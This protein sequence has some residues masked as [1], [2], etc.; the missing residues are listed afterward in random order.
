MLG[1]HSPQGE[2]FRPDHLLREHVGRDSFYVALS[3]ARVRLFRDE[4][5]AGLYGERGRPSVP[6]SQLC[7]ALLLQTR[8][9]VSDEEAIKRSAYDLRWKVALGLDLE[10]KLCAKSTLQLFRAKLILHESY[11]KIFQASVEECRKQGLL[12]RHKLEVAIDTTP[13]LGRGAVKDTFNLV[14][15]QIRRLVREVAK[16]KGYELGELVAQHGLGRHFAS[17]FKSQ[18]DL[19]WDDAEQKRAVVAQLVGDARV[20]LE[21]AK[22]ALRGY[23]SDAKQTRAVREARELLADLV[24][25][26]IEEEPDDGGGPQIRQGTARDRIVSATDPE[27]RHGR[28]SRSKRFDGYKASVAVDTKAGVVVSTDV[29]PGN[30]HDAEG[31]GDL[32]K[33]GS[34]AA[35]REVERVLADT[36]YGTT[37]AREEIAE[38]TNGAEVV[39]KVPPAPRRKGAEFTADDFDV[40]LDAGVATCPAGK[41]SVRH[42]PAKGTTPHRF[43]FSRNDCTACPMRSRC[44]T[45]KADARSL[46]ISEGHEDLRRLRRRQRTKRFKETYR[47]RS[48]VEH[49]IARLVQLGIRQARYLGRSKVAFQVCIAAAVANLVLACASGSSLATRPSEG[50]QPPVGALRFFW[51]SIQAAVVAIAASMLAVASIA[52]L[53]RPALEKAPSRPGF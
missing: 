16:L 44:T 47:R 8:E 32:V 3:R 19:D 6:P 46:T 7:V 23:A 29:L 39:V 2:L 15:D 24:L 40:D 49:R 31:V 34:E 4:D 41:K 25:Q 9:G 37:G 30:A 20:A 13:I 51:T 22:A 18:L 45:S 26:D 17:S 14:S 12:R 1:R 27:M 43:R 52:A 28:K 48:R 38:A 33:Q 21:L 53:P 36:A 11:Q 50:L 10:E 5:F 35:G 42:Q